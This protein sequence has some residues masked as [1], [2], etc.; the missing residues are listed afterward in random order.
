MFEIRQA[1]KSDIPDLVELDNECFDSYYYT[2]TKF[3]KS[4]FHA[5]LRRK[6]S[7]LFVAVR[8]SHLIGYVAGTIRGSQVLSTA[9]LDSIAVSLMERKQ[10]I[11]NDLLQLFIQE[12]K[13]QACTSVM[14]EVASANVEGLDFFSKRGFQGIADLPEYYGKG[15]NGLLM[16]L[17]V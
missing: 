14:L 1:D 5:Y 11:G 4:D 8:D 17:C 2:K 6:K 3:G 12:A 7:L 13:Q 10:G 9:H 16:E 15:L